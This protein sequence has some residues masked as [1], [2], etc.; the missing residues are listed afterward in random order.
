MINYS[1][2]LTRYSKLKCLNNTSSLKFLYRRV[3]QMIKLNQFEN[4]VEFVNLFSEQYKDDVSGL[5][6]LLDVIKKV[7]DEPTIA[8]L[9]PK[10]ISLIEEKIGKKLH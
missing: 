10:L 3:N 1:E 8:P 6:M 9:M 5:R 4:I 2:I 7:S